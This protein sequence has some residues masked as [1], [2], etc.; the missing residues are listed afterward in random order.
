MYRTVK[1]NKKLCTLDVQIVWIWRKYWI[2]LMYKIVK[3]H[4]E[5]VYIK[6]TDFPDLKKILKILDMLN[7]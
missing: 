1:F 4:W 2:R 7:V 3:I 6:Y 5:I